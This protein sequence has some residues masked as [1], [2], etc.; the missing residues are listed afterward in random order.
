[1][2]YVKSVLQPGETVRYATDIHWIVY[3]PGFLLLALAAVVYWVGFQPAAHG[4]AGIW[5]WL[6]GLLFACSAVVGVTDQFNPASPVALLTCART[7][8]H[9]RRPNQNARRRPLES[10]IGVRIR[11][12]EPDI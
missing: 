6:A 2:S 9:R 10:L 12:G 7:A 8:G 1:M 4:A 5:D 3:I 11:F